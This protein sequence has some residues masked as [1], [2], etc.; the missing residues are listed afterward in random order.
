[1]EKSVAFNETGEHD[2]PTL[3]LD[4]YSL[5][6]VPQPTYHPDDPLNWSP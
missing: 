4:K 3:K 6:L 2:P 1:M 5:P